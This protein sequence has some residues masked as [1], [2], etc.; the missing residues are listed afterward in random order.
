MT[1]E[2]DE[3]DTLPSTTVRVPTPDGIMYVSVS[4][5]NGVPWRVDIIIGKAGSAVMAWAHSLA[6][7]STMALQGG[8][9]LNELIDEIA[10][11][12]SDKLTM[13]RRTEVRSG[14]EGVAI[15]FIRYLE[16][17]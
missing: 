17:R 8:A 12:T 15:A 14:P 6:R 9:T 2:W 4:E 11:V 10:G 13:D 1:V 5:F 3:P 16:R 7:L